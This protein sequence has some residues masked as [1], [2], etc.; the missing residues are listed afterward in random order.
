[1]QLL[2]GTDVGTGVRGQVRVWGGNSVFSSTV[3][4]GSWG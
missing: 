3:R 1:M 4:A 2:A